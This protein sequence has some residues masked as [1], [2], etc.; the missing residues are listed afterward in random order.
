MTQSA[1]LLEYCDL[2]D[3]FS[4]REKMDPNPFWDGLKEPYIRH[5]A[6]SIAQGLDF[7]H[8]LGWMHRD[9]KHQHILMK[10][11]GDSPL[12]IVK[13][14]DFG[15]ATKAASKWDYYHHCGTDG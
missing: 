14:A 2:E 13:L 6:K 8:G 11:D 3:L 15:L 9:I 12:P 4:W 10:K 5:I 1:V 7:L